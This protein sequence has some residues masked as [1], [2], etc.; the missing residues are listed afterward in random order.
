MPTEVGLIE[1]DL[2]FRSPGL[3]FR[4]RVQRL[5]QPLVDTRDDF[6][7]QPHV[8]AQPV[9]RHELI[10]LLE[11]CDLTLVVTKRPNY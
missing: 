2:A 5:T 4:V 10:E 6:H 9:S 1:F 3:E 8:L 11:D 7:V